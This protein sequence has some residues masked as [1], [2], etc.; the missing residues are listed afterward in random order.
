MT[1][2]RMTDEQLLTTLHTAGRTPDLDLVQTWVER[3]PDLIPDLLKTLAA[4]PDDLDDYADIHA[5]HLL[6][7]AREEAALPVFAEI[8]RDPERDYFLEWVTPDLAHYGPAA[9]PYFRELLLDPGV[10]TYGRS[11]AAGILSAIAIEYTEEAPGIIAALRQLLPPVDGRGVPQVDE[12]EFDEMWTWAAL[13][14][15][16]L[17]DEESRPQI[18]PLYEYQ[19]LE[20]WVIGDIDAY[21]ERM[22]T[23]PTAARKPFDIFAVYE[24]LHRQARQQ[25]ERRK[26]A[27]AI[28]RVQAERQREWESAQQSIEPHTH[29][30]LPFGRKVGRNE[31]CP[32]G[33]GRKY[34]RCHG[35]P[36][37]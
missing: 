11:S 3:T 1:E 4:K 28:R 17:Q 7:A 20:A 5:A 34:K 35:R 32:C 18:E 13:E 25:E 16:R 9:V 6:L 12:G 8:F 29:D 36:G 31:P 21:D 30:E 37:K 33:S 19:L 23:G 24:E 10:V 26:Q 15:G 2:D 22:A 14:L 27:D